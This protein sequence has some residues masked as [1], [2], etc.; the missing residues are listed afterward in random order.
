[1]SI[2]AFEKLRRKAQ[3]AVPSVGTGAKPVRDLAGLRQQLP[4]ES[5]LE[6]LHFIAL[7]G[8]RPMIDRHGRVLDRN[9]QPCAISKLPPAPPDYETNPK[10][11]L[12]VK[13]Q[14]DVL[15]KLTA[16]VV[17]DARPDTDDSDAEAA[18]RAALEQ[19]QDMSQ[20]DEAQLL[21]LAEAE[22]IEPDDDDDH[23]D[24]DRE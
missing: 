17:P 19:N 18:R 12:T 11:F 4:V 23:Q 10:A 16:K 24:Q 21:A 20:M 3:S 22:I 15:L 8:Y 5:Y 14:A 9:N 6:L 1:M 7:H 2:Q 13:E